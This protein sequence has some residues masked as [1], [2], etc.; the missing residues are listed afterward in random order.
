MHDAPVLTFSQASR[1]AMWH[2]L[3]EYH[4]APPAEE[5]GNRLPALGAMRAAHWLSHTR[6]TLTAPHGHS[7]ESEG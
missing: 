5:Q 2:H 7:T 1:Y 6:G 3:R 4:G